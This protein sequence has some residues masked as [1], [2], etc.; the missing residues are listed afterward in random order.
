MLEKAQARH[1]MAVRRLEILET[2]GKGWLAALEELWHASKDLRRQHRGIE[3]V[4][5]GAI[6]NWNRA[7]G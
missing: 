3:R 5:D 4:I 7:G 6:R 1:R 2:D